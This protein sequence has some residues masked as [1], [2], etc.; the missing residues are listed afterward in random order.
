[1]RAQY[2]EAWDNIRGR[3]ER[4]RASGDRLATASFQSKLFD[5]A[6]VRRAEE[7]DQTRRGALS[8]YTEA[9]F[10]AK[11]QPLLSTAPIYPDLEKL[12]LTFSL[13]KM[14]E[15]LGPDD[16]FVKKVLGKKSPAELASELIDGTGLAAWSFAKNSSMPMWPARGVDRSDDRV[17]PRDRSGASRGPQGSEDDLT[18]RD[19]VSE[20]IADASSWSRAARAIRM[21]P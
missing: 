5:H 21:R 16:D 14:R 13:T 2:G 12:T 10:P 7:V 3:A 11:R 15:W 4:Y 19:Q 17:R 6:R 9:N 18:P 1:M 20:Q 8:E